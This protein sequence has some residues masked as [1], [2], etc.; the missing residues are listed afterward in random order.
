MENY[1]NAQGLVMNFWS[2]NFLNTPIYY[3]VK[4]SKKTK[5]SWR[6]P[7]GDAKKNCIWKKIKVT[8]ICLILWRNLIWHNEMWVEKLIYIKIMLWILNSIGWKELY[9]TCTIYMYL[10]ISLPTCS[11]RLCF[12]YIDVR[13]IHITFS[14]TEFCYTYTM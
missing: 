13:M 1:G 4:H 8:I 14:N 5:S 3:T 9:T 6:A 7:V 11:L 10:L 12:K 2:S